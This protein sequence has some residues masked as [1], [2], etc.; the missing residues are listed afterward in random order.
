[1]AALALQAVRQVRTW[2]DSE[3]LMRHALAVTRDN[4][5]AHVYLG[6]ALL[7]RGDAVEAIAHWREAARLA[8]GYAAVANNLAWLLAT[9][10]DPRLRDPAAAVAY[11]EQAARGAGDDPAV[12]DTLATA[13]AAAGDFDSAVRSEERALAGASGNAPLE[14]GI[15]QR[16][17]LFRRGVPWVER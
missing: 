4:P 16:L 6:R 11:A 8:P 15:R 10:P 12:L 13:Q 17:A 2:S 5:V 9:H 7:E 14:A 1:V 3:T